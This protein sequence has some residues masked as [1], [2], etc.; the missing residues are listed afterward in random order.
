MSVVRVEWALHTKTC[1]IYYNLLFNRKK[2]KRLSDISTNN[3]E[4]NNNN[5]GLSLKN[6]VPNLVKCLPLF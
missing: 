4:K 5:A 2:E 3:A 6:A 1:L